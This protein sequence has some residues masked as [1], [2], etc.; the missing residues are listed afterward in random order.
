[1]IRIV[2]AAALWQTVASVVLPSVNIM[3]CIVSTSNQKVLRSDCLRTI[4]FSPALHRLSLKV[5]TDRCAWSLLAFILVV[6]ASD[7]C[8]GY[9]LQVRWWRTLTGRA[10]WNRP[11]VS[12]TSWLNPLI[13]C[14]P[15]CFSEALAS[16]LIRLQK[17]AKSTRMLAKSKM[18]LKSPTSKVNKVSHVGSPHK[19]GVSVLTSCMTEHWHILKSTSRHDLFQCFVNILLITSVHVSVSCSELCVSGPAVGAVWLCGFLAGVSPWAQCECWTAEEERRDGGEGGEGKRPSQQSQGMC[20]RIC[21]SLKRFSWM[22][23]C[24]FLVFFVLGKK[25]QLSKTVMPL[26]NVKAS[27]FTP[28]KHTQVKTAQ[29]SLHIAVL[30]RKTQ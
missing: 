13:S 9:F 27:L 8:S 25:Q 30:W 7:C 16:Y 14:A 20:Y 5:N 11:S 24:F 19:A 22:F 1:M 10:S 17:V 18:D 3:H 28:K 29:C 4:S 23:F 15:G 21:Q 26:C 6:S 12:F 2:V